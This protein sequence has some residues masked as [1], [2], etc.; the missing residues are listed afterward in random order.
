MRSFLKFSDLVAGRTTDLDRVGKVTS[1]SVRKYTG[2]GWDEWV[3]L[4][5]RAGASSWTHG[6]IAAYLKRKHRLTP[7]WQQGVALGFEIATGRRKEG[8]DIRGRYMVTATKSIGVGA[9]AVWKFAESTE[10]LAIWLRPLSEIRLKPKIQFETED[11]YFGEIRTVAKQRRAR[12]QWQHPEWEKHTV[13]E[14]LLV[15]KPSGKSILVFNHTGI[16]DV[17]TREVL[18]VRWRKVADEIHARMKGDR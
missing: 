12:L 7:W 2:K 13:I 1:D 18:R 15:P 4:L 11:G 10:G 14:L 16:L 17:R 5:E 8:Q 9:A 6:E 3:P